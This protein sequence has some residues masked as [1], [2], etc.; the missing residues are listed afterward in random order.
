[1]GKSIANYF[2]LNV[3]S[4]GRDLMVA[5]CDADILGKTF[6][7]GDLRLE[8]NET[9]YKGKLVRLNEALNFLRSASIANIVGVNIVR[10]AIQAGIIHRDAVIWIGGQPHAQLVKII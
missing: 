7:E 2:Y 8:V 1:M 3:W 9:F 10:E 6:V 4:R 5:V